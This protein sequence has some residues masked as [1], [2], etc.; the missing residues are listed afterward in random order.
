MIR[1]LARFLAL[2]LSAVLLVAAIAVLIQLRPTGPAG[3]GVLGGLI[4]AAIL[5]PAWLYRA[6]LAWTG[7]TPREGEGAGVA[8]GVGIETA[9]RRQDDTRDDLDLDL[10]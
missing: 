3:W 6:L 9:R 1:F 8:M 5:G 10:D 4:V 2:S 7:V